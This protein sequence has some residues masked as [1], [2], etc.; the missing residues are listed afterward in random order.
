MVLKSSRLD[1]GL[2]I[3][4]SIFCV[5][6][7]VRLLQGAKPGP[8]VNTLVPSLT[9]CGSLGVYSSVWMCLSYTCVKLQVGHCLDCTASQGELNCVTG[10][11]C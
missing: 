10:V 2:T 9:C 11:Q 7:I 5:C 8:I 3:Y 4:Q 1:S 6:F